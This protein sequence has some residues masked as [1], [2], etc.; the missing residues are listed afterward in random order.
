M[1]P[2][3]GYALEF[4]PA[5]IT[6]GLCYE[7]QPRQR[8]GLPSGPQACDQFLDR[9]LHQALEMRRARQDLALDDLS[10]NRSG[11]EGQGP[12]QSTSRASWSRGSIRSDS[13]PRDP[14][15]L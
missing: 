7:G 13:G 8:Q 9:P 6:L 3:R 11:V 15:Q 2:L 5:L 4:E 10:S 1:R 14:A 12:D